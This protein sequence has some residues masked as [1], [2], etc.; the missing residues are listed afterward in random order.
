MDYNYLLTPDLSYKKLK[1]SNFS[2]NSLRNLF[3][4]HGVEEIFGISLLHKHYE[5]KDN[6][7]LVTKYVGNEIIT[8]P[9]IT[10]EKLLTPSVF[11]LDGKTIIPYEYFYDRE[12]F[13]FKKYTNFL[14]DLYL[15]LKELNLHYFLGVHIIDQREKGD[16]TEK[17]I[18]R[19]NILSPYSG[20]ISEDE[21]IPTTWQFVKNPITRDCRSKKH[22]NKMDGSHYTSYSHFS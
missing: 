2:I 14:K 8:S 22:C 9:E 21:Y 17:T 4:K 1:E 12:Y 15:V 20:Y 3:M 19:S 16:Y 7:V 5:K 18:N 6:E 13:D 11:G 10:N